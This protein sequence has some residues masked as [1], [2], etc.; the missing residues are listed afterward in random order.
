ML[1][2]CGNANHKGN[3]ALT[4]KGGCMKKFPISEAY[5]CT[6]CDGWFHKD[7]ILK[8]FKME[9]EHDWG[10]QEER[11]KIQT[12]FSAIVFYAFRYVLGRKTYAVSEVSYY[13]T[14][15]WDLLH[16]REKQAMKQE[17]EI[18]I[19]TNNAGMEMDIENWKKI[20]TL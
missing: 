9:K 1:I 2:E 3:V 17:I 10:R 12:D 19:K 4:Y 7:C 13:I 18:A 6:G 16:D 14:K 15:N 8:H 20:L 5:R 11:K